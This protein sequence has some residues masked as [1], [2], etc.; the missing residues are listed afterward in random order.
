MSILRDLFLIHR[1]IVEARE[2]KLELTSGLED[3]SASRSEPLGASTRDLAA[4]YRLPWK[5]PA[6]YARTPWQGQEEGA[7]FVR[8]SASDVTGPWHEREEPRS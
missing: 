7:H 2:K 6:E 5:K 3:E 4:S 8:R 1:R